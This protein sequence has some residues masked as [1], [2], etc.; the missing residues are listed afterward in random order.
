MFK[1]SF[2]APDGFYVRPSSC[3]LHTSQWRPA[4][5]RLTVVAAKSMNHCDDR[6]MVLSHVPGMINIDI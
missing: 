2:K 1:N 5:F 4:T 6:L 3:H